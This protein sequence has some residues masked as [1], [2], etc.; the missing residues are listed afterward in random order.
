[1]GGGVIIAT[2]TI[3]IDGMMSSLFNIQKGVGNPKD[4]NLL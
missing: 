4:C 3:I 2:S 1:M